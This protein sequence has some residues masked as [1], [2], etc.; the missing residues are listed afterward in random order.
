MSRSNTG[1]YCVLQQAIAVKGKMPTIPYCVNIRKKKQKRSIV[2]NTIRI[3]IEWKTH[4]VIDTDSLCY[5]L[6]PILLLL[7]LLLLSFSLYQHMIWFRFRAVAIAD[8]SNEHFRQ[9]G[10]R[11]RMCM[12]ACM[13]VLV[14]AYGSARLY[15]HAYISMPYIGYVHFVWMRVRACIRTVYISVNVLCTPCIW[16]EYAHF[17]AEKKGK[18]RNERQRLLFNRAFIIAVAVAVVVHQI[19]VRSVFEQRKQARHDKARQGKANPQ[20]VAY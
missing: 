5:W 2:R 19:G 17:V 8:S 15:I 6:M 14:L 4:S 3:L 11:V 7:L 16:S 12:R 10:T 9:C 13:R 20:N 1:H 18:R